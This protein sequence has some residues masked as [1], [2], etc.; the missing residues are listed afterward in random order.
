MKSVAL[1]ILSILLICCNL[2]SQDQ[3]IKKN[4]DTLSI[5]VIEL[6]DKALIYS[7]NSESADKIFITPFTKLKL[8]IYADGTTENIITDIVT[9]EIKI[10]SVKAI[11]F[12]ILKVRMGFWGPIICENNKKYRS[13]ELYPLFY[14][15]NTLGALED[16]K[17]GKAIK[18]LANICGLVGGF[19]MGYSIAK[20]GLRPAIHGSYIFVG[21]AM[22]ALMGLGLSPYSLSIFKQAI[23]PYNE[24]IKT[25][26]GLTDNGLGFSMSF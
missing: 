3:L 24:V 26:F 22:L 7:K 17:R 15:T 4:G 18:G 5:S 14:E 11:G 12:P 13:D 2:C 16:Y 6:T 23:S 8:L 25:R 21:G 10:D 9:A 20:N 19:G 1:I